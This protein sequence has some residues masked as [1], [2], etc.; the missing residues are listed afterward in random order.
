MARTE[1]RFRTALLVSSLSL[2]LALAGL[3]T[4]LGISARGISAPVT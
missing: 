2:L 4:A 1:A 3:V